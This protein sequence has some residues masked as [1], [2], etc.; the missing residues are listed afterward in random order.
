MSE[1]ENKVNEAEET[2]SETEVT[3]EKPAETP[4]EE[5]PAEQVSDAVEETAEE[6]KEAAD[7][8]AE[9]IEKTVE[10]LRRKIK[11]ISSDEEK[12]D[13]EPT[14]SVDFGLNEEQKA[15]IEEIREN[16]MKSVNETISEVKKKAD[17]FTSNPDVRKTIDFL[18]AN[19][20]KAVDTARAKI[21]EIREKP[22]LKRTF[23]SAEDAVKGFEGTARKTLDSAEEKAK[24][25][26]E[27]AK[28][29]VDG[30]LTEEKMEE[31]KKGIEKAE[32]AVNTTVDSAAKA[33]NDFVNK[34]EVQDTIDK[35]VSTAK[36]MAEKGVSAIN[37][38]FK[39]RYRRIK[40]EICRNNGDGI[41]V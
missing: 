1:L 15:K 22:E 31:I 17:E 7:H 6:I 35:T 38:M 16:T 23:D 27:S 9:S 32:D 29:T 18:R 36:E 5:T 3:A 30:F 19:A 40:Y 14:P 2:A 39:K 25:F 4:A 8:A 21:E 37:S 26:S 13:D 12:A 24:E 34:P 20:I 41:C 11:E 28:K 10:D 33:I